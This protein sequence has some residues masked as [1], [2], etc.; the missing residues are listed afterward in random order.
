MG[1]ETISL[2]FTDLVG[3]TELATRIG[4]VVA[5]ELRKEHFALLRSSCEA[6]SGREVK[7]L[8]DGLMLAFSSVSN[9]LDAAAAAQRAIERRNAD[10]LHRFEVRVG[11]AVGE[12][13]S[14]E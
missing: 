13:V 11:V 6:A 7:N 1:V 12:A 14:E 4:P 2:V 10:A 3:S 8:G 9:A 5:E